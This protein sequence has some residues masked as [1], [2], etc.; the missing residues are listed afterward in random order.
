[1]SASS[2]GDPG[3]ADPAGEP[4]DVPAP[5]N[6]ALLTALTTEHF[7]LQGARAATIS[8]SSRAALYISAVASSLV[9]LGFVAQVSRVGDTFRAFA[10]TVL[11]TLFVLGLFTWVRL[12]ENGVEDLQYL[13]AINRI[14]GYY[15]KIE[16]DSARY[17]MMS[18][19]EDAA[20]MMASQGACR[21]HHRDPIHLR[22][23]DR[24]DQQRDS[25]RGPCARGGERIRRR[26]RGGDRR[27]SRRRTGVG[28]A[29]PAA[30]SAGSARFSFQ[31][32]QASGSRCGGAF[33]C[34][35]SS[36][37]RQS[38]R[39]PPHQPTGA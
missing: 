29:A 13:R 28:L 37:R 22:E 30:R 16:P 15:L 8:D 21:H 36:P 12:T 18:A 2:P 19:Q 7:T 33:T 11:P 4:P 34:A 32:R 6:T 1:M 5:I 38:C 25:R 9:A 27:G 39:A 24:G 14:R 35:S 17:F 20:S 26:P 3:S 23:H 10:F 31:T